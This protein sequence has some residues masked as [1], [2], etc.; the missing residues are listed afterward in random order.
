MLTTTAD[1]NVWADATNC[2]KQVGGRCITNIFQ[3]Y[4]ELE[5]LVRTR[6]CCMYASD[7]CCLLLIPRHDAAFYECL[8]TA[9]DADDL[10]NAWESYRH[11]AGVL[12]DVCLSIIGKDPWCG[13]LAKL[14]V[15]EAGFI[16]GRR[17]ARMRNG[18]MDNLQMERILQNADLLDV[19][20]E[21]AKPGDGREIL[22]L[23]LT[24][25]D[26]RTD[27]LPECEEIETNIAKKQVCYIRNDGALAALH[28][29]TRANKLVY[30]WYDITRKE[31]RKNFLHLQIMSFLYKYWQRNK[32]I[33]RAYSWR[34]TANKRLLQ[35]AKQ[36]N[37]VEDGV[38]IY[39]LLYNV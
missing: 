23:L 7:R 39:K 26:L 12:A 36:C 11:E 22:D 16:L 34:D 38:Y 21:W 9:C 5:N 25:F 19:N 14:L 3:S 2:V 35:L 13:D 32:D 33:V 24:E 15:S 29:F 4:T 37:Q 28:Y 30:G 8:F 1:I 31:F 17:I 20:V 18:K 6:S 10:Y 27:T